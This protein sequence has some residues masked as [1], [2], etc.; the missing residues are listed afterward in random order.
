MLRQNAAQAQAPAQAPVE[1][2]GPAARSNSEDAGRAV[3]GPFS[4][5]WLNEALAACFGQPL[6]GLSATFGDGAVAAVGA[7]ATTTGADMAFGP[8]IAE[9]QDDPAALETIAHEVAH[10]LAG[11]GSGAHALDQAGDAGE[12]T[13]E[14]A[15]ARFAAWVSGGMKGAPPRLRPAAGGQAEVHREASTQVATLTGTP[16]LSRGSSGGQVRTLQ[17]LLNAHGA[18][19]DVDGDFG[20]ATHRAVVAFQG[21]HRLAA[22]GVVG[23]RTAAAL[24]GPTT[25]G[26]A[27]APASPG[28]AAPAAGAITG[29][30]PLRWGSTGAA[31]SAVQT[32]LN[33][34]GGRLGVDGDYGQ[35]TKATVERFQA[36]NHLAVD[37]VVGPGTAARLNAASPVHIGGDT[38]R[39]A[40]APAQP[41][42]GED[43]P[44]GMASA[45]FSIA[46]FACHDGSRTPP[47]YYGN[48][49]HLA[50]QLEVLRAELGTSIHVNSG[51]R[52]PSYNHS[53]EGASNSQ[54][55][56]GSA[57]DITA[58]GFSASQV[59]DTVERLIRA[60][61]MEE[62]GLGRYATFVHYD[63]RGSRARW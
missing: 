45:H 12:A 15:G 37:G 25:V 3:A 63:V 26:D 9:R 5:P 51:Y 16:P 27:P 52:S 55:L 7:N 49:R 18:D 2:A 60:G 30:P 19:L 34:L 42:H 33:A 31:V 44:A 47:E 61:R 50:S 56:T 57:A 40:P 58:G 14:A 28:A 43:V 20:N 39:P 11:G 4:S 35:V 17:S 38:Q 29:A 21:S 32:R 23:P 10:A 53:I 1:S 22:D 36:A 6:D 13:A 41:G 54:H 62:G 59:A 48:I 46:E 8:G 24:S